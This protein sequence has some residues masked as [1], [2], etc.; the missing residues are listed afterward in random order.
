MAKFLY[1]DALKLV[2]AACL[3]PV[4]WRFVKSTQK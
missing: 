1:G 2:I 4:A 3:M